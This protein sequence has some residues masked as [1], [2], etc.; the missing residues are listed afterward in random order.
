MGV[1]NQ[2]KEKTFMAKE[3]TTWVG[4]AISLVSLAGISLTFYE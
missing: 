1:H 4:K 3:S 2:R